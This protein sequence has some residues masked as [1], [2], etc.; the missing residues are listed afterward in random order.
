MTRQEAVIFVEKM[1]RFS[2]Q[3]HYWLE[4]GGDFYLPAYDKQLADY[5]KLAIRFRHYVAVHHF[6]Y[7]LER[8]QSIVSPD[9]LADYLKESNRSLPRDV[10]VSLI[11]YVREVKKILSF[12][13]QL[14][15]DK[16]GIYTSLVKGL[17]NAEAAALLRRTV[18]AGYLDGNFQPTEDTSH[19]HLSVIAFAVSS[20]LG[21]KENRRWV[22]FEKQWCQGWS[23]LS[24]TILPVQHPEKYQP[25]IDLFPEVDFT[26][27]LNP[28][29][30]E[31]FTAPRN[32]SRVERIYQDLLAGHYIDP[33]TTMKQFKGIFRG[34]SHE[35]PVNWI[36][37][38]RQLSYLVHL[39]FGPTNKGIRNKTASNFLVA[40]QPVH[41]GTF[42]SGFSTLKKAGQLKTYNPELLSI[43][44]RYK[45]KSIKNFTVDMDAIAMAEMATKINIQ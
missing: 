40:G 36:G 4:L 24:G 14:E 8:I 32:M 9:E 26:P 2:K 15:L 27:L 10:Y 43:A 23:K 29:H 12:C 20:M 30:E 6:P 37:T 16:K 31:K 5:G 25:V 35:A 28:V 44:N 17:D 7:L 18:L 13:R 42:V 39:A 34:N 3:L 33:A 38:G 41:L 22:L 21:F 19:L 1:N 11:T 45:R